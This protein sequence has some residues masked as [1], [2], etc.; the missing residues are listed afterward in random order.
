MTETYRSQQLTVRIRLMTDQLSL[1]TARAPV[2]QRTIIT[3]PV[4]RMCWTLQ[5]L[6]TKSGE[7]RCPECRAWRPLDKGDDDV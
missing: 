3:C 5:K 7:W 6:R 2:V 4:C 1:F